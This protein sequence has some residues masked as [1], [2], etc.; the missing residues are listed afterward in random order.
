MRSEDEIFEELAL[1]ARR[2]IAAS[3]RGLRD[4]LKR[5]ADPNPWLDAYPLQSLAAATAVGFLAG[6]SMTRR[7][8]ERRRRTEHGERDEPR[9]RARG[10]GLLGLLPVAMGRMAVP[11]VTSLLRGL[12]SPNGH[13]PDGHGPNGHG[14]NGHGPAR[15]ASRGQARRRAE[16]ERDPFDG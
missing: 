8:A 7:R 9:R 11:V 5:A 3:A 4:A 13:G 10:A 2:D 14:R 1:T 15:H 16:P 12:I 6:R